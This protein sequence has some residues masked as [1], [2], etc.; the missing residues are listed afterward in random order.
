MKPTIEVPK[1]WIEGLFKKANFGPQ[2]PEPAENISS[3]LAY[4]KSFELF[5][6]K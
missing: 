4:I 1:E 6:N 5:L 3:L 2:T